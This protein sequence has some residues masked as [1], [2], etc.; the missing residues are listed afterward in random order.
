MR[1]LMWLA[2]RLVLLVHVA[3]V[4]VFFMLR[5]LISGQQLGS[6]DGQQN[7]VSI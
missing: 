1:V 7:A 5:R 6:F 3:A 2:P 4:L